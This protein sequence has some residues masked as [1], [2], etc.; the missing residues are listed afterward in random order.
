MYLY[1]F[2]GRTLAG[3]LYPAVMFAL[4]HLSPTSVLGF[5]IVLV[6]GAIYLGLVYG[7]IAQRTGSIR[8]TIVAH[9]LV[10]MMGLSFA[11]LIL[12]Y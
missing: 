11:S 7:W 12:G 8:Y 9:I 6:S 2:P 3:W 10:N 4:W 1:L 5:P